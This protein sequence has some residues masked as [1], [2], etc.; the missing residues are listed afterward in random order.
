MACSATP[1]R[2]AIPLIA[3]LL[4]SAAAA[5]AQNQLLNPGFD[6]NLTSWTT[7]AANGSAAWDALDA[8]GDAGSGSALLT[9]V[10][11]GGNTFAGPLMQC[12]PVTPGISYDASAKVRIA[13]GQA[14]TGYAILQVMWRPN[15]D[16]SG[17]LDY[18]QGP[19]T[20]TVGTW[21]EISRSLVPPAAARSALIQLGLVKNE[22]GGTL[23]V[24]FDD[25]TLQ[26]TPGTCGDP[27]TTLCL[28]G[29]RFRV[30]MIWE[31]STGQTGAGQA[32][33]LSDDSGYFWFFEQTNAEV[34]TKI[35]D[36][37]VPPYNHFWFFAA[38]MTNVR[39]VITVDDLQ[40]QVRKTYT[41][42]QGTPFRPLQDN[43]AFATCP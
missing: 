21:I 43:A 13:P 24:N 38:G 32:V 31:T 30:S 20:A 17:Y 33:P 19:S 3:A 15:N 35:H 29:G 27:A 34:L 8:A 18:T 14:R 42:P 26:L 39:V 6:H 7:S 10:A 9:N 23:T 1:L 41:N 22:A 36:A 4:L 40:A 2:T 25:V 16:C 12:V 11:A 5:P 37:C 28:H